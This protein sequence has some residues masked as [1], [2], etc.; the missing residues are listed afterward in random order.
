MILL[1]Q[2]HYN[3]KKR[4]FL[5]A[6]LAS[7]GGSLQAQ[8]T[9]WQRPAPLNNY[10]NNTWID[11]TNRY[12]CGEEWWWVDQIIARQF[13]TED[14]LQVYGIAAMMV[15]EYFVVRPWLTDAEI[16]AELR[17]RYSEDPTFDNCEE[18]LL[19]FQYRGDGSPLMQQLGDSLPV[20]Y[21]HTTPT[22]YMMSNRTPLGSYTDTMPKPVYE[23][24]F[25]TPQ[26]VHDTFFAGYT[27]GHW[28]YDKKDSVWYEKRP[29]FYC[30]G[31]D[32]TCEGALYLSYK[33]TVALYREE[34]PNST[35]T[36][37]TFER[38]GV[39][40]A[41]Y[42]FPI[43]TPEPPIDTTHVD[44]GDT[45]HVDPGDTTHVDPGDTVAI[46]MPEYFG[47]YVSVSPN[48]ATGSAE[49]LSSFGMSRVEVFNAAGRKVMDLKAEGLKATL[50][51]SK[52]P[53][54]AYLLRI[55][56]PQGM[57]TKKLVVR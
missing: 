47:R 37:W 15:D 8:D 42:I 13:I 26:T 43:L 14:T 38:D 30:L 28:G 29:S 10:F 45:T 21:L 44:P 3:M 56:T 54:G 32:H 6:L 22:H 25:S 55:H 7:F 23:R 24:Y 1:T 4:I 40:L 9:V 48:P 51:V 33:E 11:T 53:S 34:A 49:V 2:K 52:L 5:L 18:S 19:L 36:W 35:H 16:Q 20:H 12:V 46:R 31:F 50:D 27:Q 41:H 39:G 17:I 57:T